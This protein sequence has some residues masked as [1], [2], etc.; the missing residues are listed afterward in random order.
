MGVEPPPKYVNR[1]LSSQF[2]IRGQ[3]SH[4]SEV[5][6]GLPLHPC[7]YGALHTM[8]RIYIRDAYDRSC[9]HVLAATA[10]CGTAAPGCTSKIV[11]HHTAS[12]DIKQYAT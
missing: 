1:E 4:F 9:T 2:G 12:S 7:S 6:V 3:D 10:E 5:K 8:S 11:K